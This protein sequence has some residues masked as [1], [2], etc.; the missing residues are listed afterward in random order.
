MCINLMN[1]V[2]QSSGHLW[3]Q[4]RNSWSKKKSPRCSQNA[5]ASMEYATAV[6]A[7]S[8]REKA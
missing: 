4:A 7:E 2:H 5:A 8:Q 3:R 6:L 1:L